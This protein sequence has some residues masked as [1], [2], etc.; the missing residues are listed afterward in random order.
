MAEGI[1]WPCTKIVAW[2][3]RLNGVP[4]K[5]TTGTGGRQNSEQPEFWRIQLRRD[6]SIFWR[7]CALG[8]LLTLMTTQLED[9]QS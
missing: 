8:I 1:I 7:G 6:L 4:G 5:S 3:G 9:F 2:T